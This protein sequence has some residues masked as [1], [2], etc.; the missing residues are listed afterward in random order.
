MVE[1]HEARHSALSSGFRIGDL[2]LD[3]R[4]INS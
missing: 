3:H 4:E 2:T 1:V